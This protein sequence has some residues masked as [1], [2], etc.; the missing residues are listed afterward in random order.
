MRLVDNFTRLFTPAEAIP[1]AKQSVH[2]DP[3]VCRGTR[4]ISRNDDLVSN[5]HRVSG[6]TLAAECT[7]SAPFHGPSLHLTGIIWSLDVDE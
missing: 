7:G 2:L 5:L 3:V 1:F 4:R 6:H